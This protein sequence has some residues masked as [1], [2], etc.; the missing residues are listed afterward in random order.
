MDRTQPLTSSGLRRHSSLTLE[1]GSRRQHGLVDV[2]VDEQPLCPTTA[3][4]PLLV[5]EVV[6]SSVLALD[7]NGP[8]SQAASTLSAEDHSPGIEHNEF[9][10]KVQVLDTQGGGGGQPDQYEMA[11]AS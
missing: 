1:P 2:T 6:E 9:K 3:P 8:T 11:H 10:S 7:A 4:G 5:A